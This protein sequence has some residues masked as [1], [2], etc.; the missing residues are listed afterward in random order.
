MIAIPSQ[1]EARRRSIPPPQWVLSRIVK[2][3]FSR[4]SLRFP[5]RHPDRKKRGKVSIR[6][7]HKGTFPSNRSIEGRVAF[8]GP[9]FR[10]GT[11]PMFR[12]N[13]NIH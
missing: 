12:S 9:P 4:S 5:P 2:P 1:R 13:A 3:R 6:N 10:H 8:M 11:K 7:E